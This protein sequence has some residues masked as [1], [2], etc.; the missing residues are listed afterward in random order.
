VLGRIRS[1]SWG[2]SARLTAS[3]VLVTLAVIVLVEAIVLGYQAPHLVTDTKLQGQVGATA[4]VYWGRLQQR[5][6]GGVPT[7]TLLGEPGQPSRPGQTRLSGDGITLVVPAIAGPISSHP[8]T[9]VVVIAADGTIIASSAPARYPPRHSAAGELPAKAAAALARGDATRASDSSGSVSWTLISGPSSEPASSR[10]GKPEPVYLYVQAPLPT[11][12][13]NPIRAW[14]ELRHQPGAGPL[15]TAAYVLL[16]AVIPV[17]VLFGLLASRRLVRRVRRLEGATLAVADGD[18]TVSLPTSGR[19]EVGR[20]ETNFN[21]MTRQL[22]SA[23]SA[24]RQRATI[25]ARAGERARIAR[26][27]HDAIS[28][29]LFSIRMIAGGL[30]KRSPDDQ[31]LRAIEQ[32]ATQATREMQA[33]LLELNPAELNDAELVPALE[34]LCDAYRSRLGIAVDAHLDDVSAP[35]A[36]EHALLRITQE[37]CTNAVRHGN[38][39]RLAVSLTRRD[40]HIELAVRDTGSGFDPVC[41]N[42]GAGLRN[43]RDR[44]AELGGTLHIDSAPGHGTAIIVRM[45]A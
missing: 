7:G 9:A 37:A 42:A 2:L 19:D 13:V 43:I 21:A 32:S 38:T 35:P 20:L 6:P 8:V 24:E 30:R 26:E 40:G 14:N 11:G 3:Y 27:I 25:E 33:L 10:T 41:T 15:V 18:Y 5:Y 22:D 36:V 28:Q 23:L 31:Q 12:F 1:R 34:D 29:H 39:R 44:V 16:I 17:G 4:K 45:P